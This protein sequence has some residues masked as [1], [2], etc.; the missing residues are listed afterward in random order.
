MRGHSV[1]AH[2]RSPAGVFAMIL[3]GVLGVVLIGDGAVRDGRQSDPILA[4][5][6]T[7]EASQQVLQDGSDWLSETYWARK[8]SKRLRQRE[9]LGYLSPQSNA[10]F[11]DARSIGRR[12]RQSVRDRGTYRTVCVRLCDGY[13]FPV[14]FS[15]TRDRFGQDEQ[16]CRSKCASDTRLFYHPSSDPNAED[17]KDRDGNLYRDL[18]NAY[19]YRTEYK[20]S[21]Q[22]QAQP[23]TDEARERHATYATPDWQQK[24]SRIAQR[25]ER[26]GQGGNQQGKAWRIVRPA[27]PVQSD[28]EIETAA[29]PDEGSAS[30]PFG[31]NVIMPGRARRMG[32]GRPQ[33][34][35]R[36]QR[37]RVS[38]RRDRKWRQR[39]FNNITD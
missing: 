7:A 13:Y 24:S 21:C 14:S 38:S 32:L 17:L 28:G 30:Q 22:C 12:S 8:R 6:G 34:V 35:A 37:P 33:P 3:A 2:L 4:K 19:V 20:P 27:P 11:E 26:K 5:A 15:T 18:V 23:W 31:V 1:F 39:M 29:V 36:P 9:Q 25:E 16:V 10:F